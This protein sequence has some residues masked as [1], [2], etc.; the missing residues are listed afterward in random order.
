[1][2]GIPITGHRVDSQDDEGERT[3]LLSTPLSRNSKNQQTL[4]NFN[5]YYSA[6]ILMYFL[7]S[8][9]IGLTLVPILTEV[10]GQ[11]T[12]LMYRFIAVKIIRNVYSTLVSL[13]YMWFVKC[14][15][16]WVKEGYVWWPNKLKRMHRVED[17]LHRE[18]SSSTSRPIRSSLFGALLVLGTG[19]AIM[20]T[21][22]II[23]AAQCLYIKGDH[24]PKPLMQTRI[25]NVANDVVYLILLL[26][27]LFFFYSYDGAVFASRSI[28]HYAMAI[29]ISSNI[30]VGLE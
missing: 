8:V 29:C 21:I 3:R 5:S 7:V 27:Q 1:M 16:K 12:N 2:A 6:T 24:G 25:M 9:G 28:F 26:S 4:D 13:V 23:T 11:S 20:I 18:E 10:S 22:S 30:W 19:S 17:H 15:S 14:K